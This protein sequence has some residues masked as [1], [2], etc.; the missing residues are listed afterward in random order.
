M[1][2]I[3]YCHQ[4]EGRDGLPL[5]T[6]HPSD[7]SS[8]THDSA[9]GPINKVSQLTRNKRCYLLPK[10]TKKGCLSQHALLR[11]VARDA[12]GQERHLLH[13]PGNQIREFLFFY[14]SRKQHKDHVL[15]TM[16]IALRAEN[17]VLEKVSYTTMRWWKER[18]NELI[19]E[20]NAED[21]H[22]LYQEF[23]SDGGE[24]S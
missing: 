2:G 11:R 8:W 4:A 17:Q 7:R 18:I 14:R 13:R 15:K 9:C 1:R 5:L 12:F 21:A 23:S 20:G 19:K 24:L 6:S 10:P 16:C 22:A 3:T